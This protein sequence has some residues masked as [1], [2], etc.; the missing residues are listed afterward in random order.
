MSTGRRRRGLAVAAL[1]L[2]AVLA[3]CSGPGAAGPQTQAAPSASGIGGR[4]DADR[5][6]LERLAQA[7]M[8]E[9]HLRALLV[10][11]TS[12][13]QEA[14]TAAFGESLPGVPATTD[15]HFRNGAMAFTYLG[16]AFARLADA[17]TLGLDDKLSRWLPELP[18]ADAV[19]LR[20]L[21]TMTSGYADYVYE[22][23][24]L[25]GVN[26]DP[27]RQWTNA[28]LLK[29][30]L[31]A[32]TVFDPGTNWSYSHTN[33]VILGEVLA[34]VTGKSVAQALDDLVLTPMGLTQTTDNDGTPR[35]PEPVLHAYTSE[36]RGFL[37]VPAGTPFYEESTFWNPSWTTAAG[38]VET[39]TIADMTRSIE[40]VGAGTQVS[41][42]SYQ[43]QVGP[44]LVG[45][46]H[47]D[48]SGRCPVCRTMT[49]ERHYGL[50]VVL[51]D[52][53]VTQTKSFAGSGATTGYLP[54][55]RL[56]VS[57]VTTYAP[58][59]FDAQGDYANASTTIFSR[60]AGALEPGLAPAP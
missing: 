14:Y 41:P 43:A 2:A 11:V 29:I 23:A 21:L 46:G 19:T 5:A 7:A 27:F 54:Q 53:W 9:F 40:I 18:R 4:S 28:E 10:R 25:D 8:G 22:P 33:Y 47:P 1:A 38:A 42:A 30:G 31:D 37:G 32:G 56:A 50:G 48:P 26:R 13:G 35:I 59:A 3:G 16:Q 17:G 49:K 24:V 34:K 51:M 12:D 6:A 52:D 20:N 44:A 45:F 57:V 58:E 55:K 15:M 60:L 36:R 39:T